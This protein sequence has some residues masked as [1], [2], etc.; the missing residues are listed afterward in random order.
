MGTIAS[1]SSGVATFPVVIA[2]QGTPAGFHAGA[3]GSV[4]ITYD[5]LT[6]VLAVPTSAVTQ[7]HGTSYVTVST[8]GKN[9][10]RAVT[11]GMSSG[12]QVEITSGL[13]AGDQ[14]V[15]TIPTFRRTGS[16]SRTGSQA[17][18]GG[19]GGFG[20]GGGGRSGSVTP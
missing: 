13:N 5:S 2:V 1:A 3:S 19:F 10:K 12:G 18:G 8:N 4:A 16:G 9:A 6:N 7:S 17:G 20:G 14:I 15:V 11:T